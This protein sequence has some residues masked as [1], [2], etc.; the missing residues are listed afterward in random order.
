L[1][2]KSQG[3]RK[4]KKG[5]EAGGIGERAVKKNIAQTLEEIQNILQK[6]YS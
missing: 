2:N 5:V 3:K 4:S 6:N 1:R